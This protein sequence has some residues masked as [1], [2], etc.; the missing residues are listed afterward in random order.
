MPQVD[1]SKP[2]AI[3][4]LSEPGWYS[5]AGQP[6]FGLRVTPAGAKSYY[7]VGRVKEPGAKKSKPKWIPIGPINSLSFGD[8]RAIALAI[9]GVKAKARHGQARFDPASVIPQEPV[10]G[11][12]PL[13]VER[14]W[15]FYWDKHGC[16]TKRADNMAKLWERH[17]RTL[18]ARV[19]A[20]LDP[21]LV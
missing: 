17:C 12:V 4:Q 20:D 1:L 21:E 8:A 18:G 2:N 15:E 13:T 5:H 19:V 7:W 11:A 14:M 10:I 16:T 6:N 9:G 3:E